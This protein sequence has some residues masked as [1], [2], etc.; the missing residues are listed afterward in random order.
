[1]TDRPARAPGSPQPTPLRG[2]RRVLALA[3]VVGVVILYIAV[4][5][6]ALNLGL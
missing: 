3:W 1:M 2:A 6:L 5:E 4:R